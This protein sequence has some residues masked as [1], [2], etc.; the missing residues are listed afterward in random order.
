M[1]SPSQKILW[2]RHTWFFEWAHKPLCQ[3]YSSDVLRLGRLHLCRGCTALWFG[4]LALGPLIVLGTNSLDWAWLLPV[5]L[6]STFTLSHP[7]LYPRWSRGL[8]DLIRLAAGCLP[9]FCIAMLLGGAPLQGGAGL[10]LIAGAYLTYR[11]MRTERRL[12]E[13]ERCPELNTGVCSGYAL[14]AEAIRSW[15]AE[16][17]RRQME[18]RISAGD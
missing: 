1:S 14:Q 2:W 7:A 18:E 3:P 8:K 15:E 6:V 5:S 10:V 17:S 9:I 12:L 4:A 11:H 16:A 13:C